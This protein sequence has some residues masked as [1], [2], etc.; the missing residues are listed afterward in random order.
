MCRKIIIL[1]HLEKRGKSD[2]IHGATVD[3]VK[4][5][6]QV[7]KRERVIP[8]PLT[9]S[10]PRTAWSGAPD[11]GSIRHVRCRCVHSWQ[12]KEITA[13][14]IKN[15]DTHIYVVQHNTYVHEH[16]ERRNPII[17]YSLSWFLMLH[18]IIMASDIFTG[19]K[20]LR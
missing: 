3:A 12:C 15:K 10:E 8:D 17:V 20:H 19:D 9:R 14:K 4:I 16:L 5:A 11:I 2:P 1:P 13:K 7:G 6:Q 18:Y